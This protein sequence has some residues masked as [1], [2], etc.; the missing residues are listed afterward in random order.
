MLALT[1][2]EAAALTGL[3]ERAVRKDVEHGILDAGSPP[4]FS[5]A[6]LVY[7]RACAAFAFDLAAQ[8]RRRLY[9]DIAGALARHVARLDLGPGWTLDVAALATEMAE[10]VAAFVTWRGCLVHRDDILGGEPVFPGTRLSVRHVGEM[11][12]RGAPPDVV[13]EDY[14]DLTELDLDFA[15]LYSAAYPRIGRPRGQAAPG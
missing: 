4:R 2:T 14:P 12:A 9:A 10:R 1:S 3:D 13:R 7:F 15:R 6:A 11:L 5:E 8:D